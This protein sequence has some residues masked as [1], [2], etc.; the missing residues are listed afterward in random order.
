MAHGSP[1]S[2]DITSKSGGKKQTASELKKSKHLWELVQLLLQ[3]AVATYVKNV[4]VPLGHRLLLE[5]IRSDL[6]LRG[7]AL[8]RD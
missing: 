7:L 8:T 1:N 6:F 5:F 4:K 3:S 2:C